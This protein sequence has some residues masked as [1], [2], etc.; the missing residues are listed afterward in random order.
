M[1]NMWSIVFIINPTIA[2]L[3]LGVVDLPSITANTSTILSLVGSVA[4]GKWLRLLINIDAIIVLAGGVLTAYIGVNGLIKQLAFDRCLPHFLLHQNNLFGTHHWIIISFFLLCVSLYMITGGDVT[5]L[6]GVFAIAFLMVLILFA[7]AN[8]SLKYSRPRLPRGVS[9]S[10]NLAILGLFTMVV[11]LIGN[12]IYNPSY[13]LYFLMYVGFFFL[14]IVFTYERLW[15]LKIVWYIV[16]NNHWL[17]PYFIDRIQDKLITMKKFTVLF[18]TN[19]SELHILNKAILYARD[20]ECCDRLIFA[21][22]RTPIERKSSTASIE[23]VDVL[24]YEDLELQPRD[25]SSMIVDNLKDNLQVLDHMYPKMKID[26]LI[27]EAEGFTPRVVKKLSEDLKIPPSFMFIRC[28]GNT[29]RYNIG[30]Y[31]GVRTIMK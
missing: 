11:G 10:W 16:D 14:V 9:A 25:S 26:L 20:N 4:G 24:T 12:V 28:P 21:H 13:L 23:T 5:I 2:I 7:W 6:S 22:I 15:I 8:I 17:R 31:G 30:E 27:I 3:T 29:F 18:F 19:T 1:F